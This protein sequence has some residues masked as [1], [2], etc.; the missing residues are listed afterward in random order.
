MLSLVLSVLT[1]LPADGAQSRVI[2]CFPGA[3]IFRLRQATLHT[4]GGTPTLTFETR[5]IDPGGR[6]GKGKPPPGCHTPTPLPSATWALTSQSTWTKRGRHWV[7]GRGGTATLTCKAITLRA[8]DGDGGLL[9]PVG[10]FEC[11]GGT[12][13]AF[14]G[15]R[16]EVQGIR[17]N[18][19]TDDGPEPLLFGPQT[20]WLELVWTEDDCGAGSDV[21]VVPR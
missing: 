16:R 6:H 21:R 15:T 17:C 1:Q 18:L 3:P 14:Q 20:E 5:T 2:Q 7:N 4:T 19:N 10:T 8:V 11:A 13:F 9:L 12:N